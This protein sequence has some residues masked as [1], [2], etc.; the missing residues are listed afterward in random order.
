MGGNIT[1]PGYSLLKLD[2]QEKKL[3]WLKR[4]IFYLGHV[5]PS[6]S[7]MFMSHGTQLKE[8]LQTCL[9][10]AQQIGSSLM[11]LNLCF[12]EFEFNSI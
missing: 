9:S 7:T 4:P 10:F 3:K 6:S 11:L 2:R 1:C 12:K 8:K 5:L